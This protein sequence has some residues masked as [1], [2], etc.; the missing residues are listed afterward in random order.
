[1]AYTPKKIYENVYN[2]F[3]VANQDMF[4][5]GIGSSTPELRTFY[6][7]SYPE[8]EVVE[9]SIVPVPGAPIRQYR[10]SAPANIGGGSSGYTPDFNTLPQYDSSFLDSV[11]ESN[12]DGNRAMTAEDLISQG[13]NKSSGTAD[14]IGDISSFLSLTPLAP[15][16]LAGSLASGLSEIKGLNE[17]ARSVG[18][19]ELSKTQ[20]ALAAANPVKGVED[21]ARENVESFL[22]LDN[23]RTDFSK[24]PEQA[25]EE[26]NYLSN[27][28][29]NMTVAELSDQL[30]NP[31]SFAEPAPSISVA[32]PAPTSQNDKL[33]VFGDF[34]PTLAPTF[35]SDYYT[36]PQQ[37]MTSAYDRPN[38]D[39]VL[40][41]SSTQDLIGAQNADMMVGPVETDYQTL[42]EK[43]SGIVNPD[44]DS[45][46]AAIVSK[47]GSRENFA[48]ALDA[49]R[50]PSRSPL[51]TSDLA[52]TSPDMGGMGGRLNRNDPAPIQANLVGE[53][54]ERGI[55]YTNPIDGGYDFNP[56]SQYTNPNTGYQE[57]LS[58]QALVDSLT[59]DRAPSITNPSSLPATSFSGDQYA[60]SLMSDLSAPV[61]VDNFDNLAVDGYSL[62]RAQNEASLAEDPNSAAYSDFGLSGLLEGL[63]DQNIDN[64]ISRSRNTDMGKY[65]DFNQK[66]NRGALASLVT[67][68]R[69]APPTATPANSILGSLFS[70]SGGYELDA[71]G[72]NRSMN[73][74]LNPG[75]LG[76]GNEDFD[77][78]G[79]M[80]SFDSFSDFSDA[81]F[82]GDPATAAGTQNNTDA[83]DQATGQ[84][85]SYGDDKIV[86]TAMNSAYGFGSFRNAIWLD[87]AKKNL[88]KEHEVGYHAIF[89]P[90]IKLAYDKNITP[91]RKILEHIA[92][93]RT[94][95]IWKIKRGRR[96]FLGSIY[97]AI[98]EPICKVVGKIV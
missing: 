1:M 55:A 15:I 97:R 63:T 65:G 18:A 35:S 36:A 88:T 4:R 45:A 16:G 75:P 84:D 32:A 59:N 95:D 67:N 90:L 37:S 10:S 40:G 38:S 12:Y 31:R 17:Y 87:Y 23:N 98:L 51:S 43:T 2:P 50:N 9:E 3:A 68:N 7:R 61:S 78:G 74:A 56:Y 92:R 29:R 83:N 79:P 62:D 82:G 6:N 34:A 27:M 58:A 19:P 44:L 14:T 69:S 49:E 52:I 20:I 60:R 26:Q 96:D 8:D 30:N 42:G 54:G 66:D 46:M 47:Y 53:I 25:R 28:D 93:H 33:G 91:V 11:F 72:A 39:T 21:Y 94:S 70:G 48:K 85:D 5:Y 71:S 76:Y 57:N 41:G 77:P 22:D 80:P 89:R 64:D 86:C 81:V 73:D 13:I 24:S